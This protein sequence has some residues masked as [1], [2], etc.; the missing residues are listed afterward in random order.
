MYMVNTKVVVL[1]PLT[2]SSYLLPAGLSSSSVSETAHWISDSAGTQA[3]SPGWPQVASCCC[4]C[5]E[6]VMWFEMFLGKCAINVLYNFND[7]Q[8]V[9][10]HY[11][12][13]CYYKEQ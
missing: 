7:K 1:S 6:T 13:S 9:D 10:R 2:C 12:H 5:E 11:R 4:C 8:D 3:S